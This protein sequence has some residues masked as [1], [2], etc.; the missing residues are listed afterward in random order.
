[1]SRVLHLTLTDPQLVKY[2]P[3]VMEGPLPCSQEPA[4]C[5]YPEPD[6][7]SPRHPSSYFLPQDPF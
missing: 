3:H 1:M 5:P 2:L 7:P 6:Q 4:T